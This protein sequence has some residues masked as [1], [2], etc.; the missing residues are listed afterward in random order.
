M[1]EPAAERPSLLTYLRA[2]LPPDPERWREALVVGLA[3]TTALGVS[4]VLQLAS[5]AAPLFAYLALQRTTVCTWRNFVRRMVI[6]V[7]AGLVV[8]PL[9]GVLVQLPWLLVPAFF[10]LVALLTYGIPMTRNPIEATLIAF[11]LIV[12]CF[13]GTYDPRAIAMDTG[14]MLCASSIGLLAATAFAQ[15]SRELSARRRLTESLAASYAGSRERL[16]QSMRRHLAYAAPSLPP[17][18]PV[19]S[20]FGAHVQLLELARQ[21]G[22]GAAADRLLATLTTAA[23]RIETYIGTVDALSRQ[24]VGRAYRKLLEPVLAPLVAALDV[25]LRRF[26]EAAVHVGAHDAVDAAAAATPWPELGSLVAAVRARQLELRREGAFTRIDV[27]QGLNANAL[28]QSLASLADVLHTPPWELHRLAAEEQIDEPPGWPWSLV[29]IDRFA[30]RYALQ[31]ALGATI[32]FVVGVASHVPQ[33]STLLWNPVLVAQTSYGA[34][35]RKA[36]LRLLGVG[37]GGALA[38]VTIVVVLANS[39]DF[40]VWLLVVLVVVTCLQ[41]AVLSRPTYWY[42]PLQVAVTYFFVLVGVRPEVDVAAALWRAF[43]TFVGTAI[44][45]SVFRLIAPDYAGRQLIARLAEL[46]RVTLVYLPKPGARL[47]PL[48]DLIAARLAAGRH[49]ADLVRLADEA[50]LEGRASGIEPRAAVDAVGIALRVSL[51]AGLVARGRATVAW[52]ALREEGRGVLDRLH[53]TVRRRIALA[54][55]V[56]EARDTAAPPGTQAHAA[57]CARARRLDARTRPDLERPLA[58]ALAYLDAARTRELAD[59]PPEALAEVFAELEHFRRLAELLP[60]LDA[61]LEETL[62]APAPRASEDVAAA[63]GLVPSGL[64]RP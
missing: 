2:E 34:T 38:V 42:G 23:E 16:A 63:R 53:E 40:A 45:F 44:L 13:S 56:V 64:T 6:G 14:T 47:A 26:G 22:L 27:A 15:A 11:P 58:D 33:L 18:A 17:D 61:A 55:D 28:V 30:L 60:R 10:V 48:D 46:L 49:A 3:T 51:R 8:I 7:A 1:T 59:W 37:V 29:P 32:A 50:R 20:A 39:N 21:E 12:A 57:A 24:D 5:F 52:P 62:L 43:G 9:G 19:H 41:Y 25:A 35:I 31:V 4:T 54:L 36:W